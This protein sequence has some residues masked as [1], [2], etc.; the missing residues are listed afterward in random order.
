MSWLAN[1]IQ[2]Y[3]LVFIYHYYKS[4]SSLCLRLIFWALHVVLALSNTS[5]PN[6]Q[7]RYPWYAILLQLILSFFFLTK[8]TENQE[9]EQN[10]MQEDNDE[11][12]DEYN[13]GMK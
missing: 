12:S 6:N 11:A 5:K 3:L 2:A 9:D 4:V 7:Y 8:D 1:S 13:L 10:A